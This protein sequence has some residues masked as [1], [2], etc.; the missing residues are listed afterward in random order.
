MTDAKFANS[1]VSGGAETREEGPY[2]CL[3]V[4]GTLIRLMGNDR[5]ANK[6]CGAVFSRDF[7]LEISHANFSR[8]LSLTPIESM[9]Q[10]LDKYARDCAHCGTARVISGAGRGC[11]Q[12]S[13]IGT[14]L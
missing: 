10:L 13:F 6:S 3:T 1:A 11:G 14:E 12:P 5:W 4:F 8:E 2:V 7:S 9:L